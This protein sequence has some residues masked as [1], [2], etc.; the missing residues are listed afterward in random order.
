VG[1]S[2]DAIA[3]HFLNLNKIHISKEFEGP[4]IT[5][6]H[7]LPRM[8]LLPKRMFIKKTLP[9]VSFVGFDSK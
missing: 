8:E 6:S 3:Q 2:Y 9:L 4:V 7:F 5:F 1:E